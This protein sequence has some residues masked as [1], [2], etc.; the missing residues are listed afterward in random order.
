V[1]GDSNVGGLVGGNNGT[2]SNSYSTGSVTG[3]SNNVGG[4][5]GYNGGTV[6]NSFYNIENVTINGGHHVTVGGLYSGQYQD[7]MTNTLVL[8]IANYSATLPLVGGYYQISSLQGI[9]D[10]LG[11]AGEATYKFRLTTDLDLTPATGFYIPYFKSAEFDGNGH[12][13]S[14]LNV[15][16][17]LNENIGLFGRLA[18]DSLVTNVGV[19]SAVVVGSSRVGGLVGYNS[20]TVSNSYATGSVTGISSI[21]GLVGENEGTISN[22]FATG[23]VIASEF[24]GGL[25]GFN[26]GTISTSYAANS[27]TAS[28]YGVG[29]LIG[30]NYGVVNDSYWDTET[31]GQ[32]SSNGGIGLTAA[33]MKQAANFSGFDLG[34][35]WEIDEGVSAPVLQVFSGST[36]QWI[37]GTDHF[38]LTAANWSLGHT[39]LSNEKVAIPY[40]ANDYVEFASGSTSVK[41]LVSDSL[42]RITGV[43]SNLTVNGVASF[44]NGLSL[45]TGSTLTANGALSLNNGLSIAIGAKVDLGATASLSI[46]GNS[47][48]LIRDVNQLQAMNA[49]LTARY[50]LAGNINAVV[51]S[52]WNETFANSGIFQGFAP[53]GSDYTGFSGSFNGLGHSIE[54]LM[55]NRPSANFIGLFGV[56]STGGADYECRSK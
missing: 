11:F 8:D 39:P 52:S 25:V 38:W 3:V 44:N 13:L 28:G 12:V 26:T 34:G 17:P 15:N 31:S 27:V 42:F 49:D 36:N 21:G 16:Q 41:R 5:M 30:S 18:A 2:V 24:A 45:A 54:N 22:S 43:N 4:L 40:L 32:G 6:V 23:S 50:A 48:T 1:D 29:G 47:Y 20:G 56:V 53:V 9:K 35:T 51:T 10:L 55:I 7:W 33:Q 37:G 14:N 19:D 46:D